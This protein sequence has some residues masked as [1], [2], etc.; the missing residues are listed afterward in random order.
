VL[1][2]LLL[3]LGLAKWTAWMIRYARVA[4]QKAPVHKMIGRTARDPLVLPFAFSRTIIIRIL[5][6]C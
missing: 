6:C 1:R 2:Q 5:S 3:S 4:K